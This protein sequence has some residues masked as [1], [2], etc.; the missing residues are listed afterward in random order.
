MFI[1]GCSAVGIP[2]P[3]AAFKE[4]TTSSAAAAL[5]QL[6]CCG[7]LYAFWA[8]RNGVSSPLTF[9]WLVNNL[10]EILMDFCHVLEVL[11]L[12]ETEYFCWY[13]IGWLC[14]IEAFHSFGAGHLPET[15]VGSRNT[16][17]RLQCCC[18]RSL[19][20]R[21]RCSSLCSSSAFM[22]LTGGIRMPELSGGGGTSWGRWC[23]FTP[24][25]ELG[26]EE[27]RAFS[28]SIACSEL[29]RTPS[30]CLPAVLL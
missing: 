24:G 18:D 28:F 21:A 14:H 10:F 30:L 27:R 29:P 13:L 11:I 3:P 8:V 4:E 22:P 5:N 20:W 12:Q 26:R 6:W 19:Q 17:A 2:V 23:P 9:C 7:L 25:G 1:Y 16:S 15:W